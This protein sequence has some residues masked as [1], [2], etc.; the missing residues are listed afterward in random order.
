M[1][2]RKAP[3]IDFARCHALFYFRGLSLAILKFYLLSRFAGLPKSEK[4]FLLL[5]IIS[6]SCYTRIELDKVAFFDSRL[7]QFKATWVELTGAAIQVL[8]GKNYGKQ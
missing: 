8:G 4:E 7:G 5:K 6:K 1:G 2:R 3:P